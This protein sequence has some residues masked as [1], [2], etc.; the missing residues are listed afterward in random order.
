[1]KQIKVGIIG[2]GR[3]GRDIHGRY[4]KTDKRYKIV[5]VTEA[6]SDRRRR[7]SEE[8]DCDIYSDHRRMLKRDDLDLVVN[9]SYSH[10]HVPISIEILKAGTNCLCEKPAAKR[11]KDVDRMAATAAKTGKLLAVYQNS[12]FAPYFLQIQ[13]VINSDVLGRIVQVNIA[14]N[15]F[16]RRYDWQTLQEFNGGNLLNTGPHPLDQGLQLFG[17]GYPEVFCF[18]DRAN[19]VG[20][21][22]DHVKLLLR[23]EDRPLINIEVSSCC[24]YPCYTYNIYGTRGG[25]KGTPGAMEWKYYL[26]KESRKPRLKR[27]PIAK[28]D[29]TPAYCSSNITWHTRK[30][31]KPQDFD[32]MILLMGGSYYSMLYKTLTEG[33]PMEVTLDQVR[34]QIWVIEQAHKQN[35]Q[36]YKAK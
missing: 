20:D 15:G 16:S 26:P 9:S 8:Y 22:E 17:E 32:D 4:L 10:M 28:P 18:M 1:M 25:L 11:A 23:G 31:E 27:R 6:L 36:I 13:K 35:P 3:S 14:F 5:A 19:T 21:A 7:A 33:A 12:R 30:W 2:Q 34:R 24:A 29:G